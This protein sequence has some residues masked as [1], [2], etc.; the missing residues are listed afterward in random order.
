[1]KV[2]IK[3]LTDSV[4]AFTH[5]TVSNGTT[6]TLHG[7][8][9]AVVD[10]DTSEKEAEL[11]GLKNARLVSARSADIV[12]EKAPE[13]EESEE[14]KEIVEPKEE[15]KEESKKR[16]RGRPKGSKNKKKEEEKAKKAKKEPVLEKAEELIDPIEEAQANSRAV[17]MT[18]GGEAVDSNMQHMVAGE[19]KESSQTKDSL[20]AMAK[21]EAEEK[22]EAVEAPV[23]EKSLDPNEKMGGTAVIGGQDGTEK[24]E[25]K[26]SILSENKD[27]DPFI[28]SEERE[29]KEDL[30]KKNNPFIESDAKDDDFDAFLDSNGKKEDS[31]SDILE[32]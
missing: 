30:D 32:L 23:D 1:M 10:I 18:G 16:G 29:I 12:V 14:A 6:L 17:V 31:D 21:L 28:D 11:V 22:G 24:V 19:I 7:K 4:I 26:N 2:E 15:S 27:Y 5:V 20:D 25:M 3:G 8:V 13:D 9:E